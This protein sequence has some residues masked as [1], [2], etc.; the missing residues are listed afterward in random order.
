MIDVWK[1]TKHDTMKSPPDGVC[2]LSPTKACSLRQSG[3]SATKAKGPKNS[4]ILCITENLKNRGKMFVRL[5]RTIKM[6]V[7]L[8]L[9]RNYIA[10]LLSTQVK[11]GGIFTTPYASKTF[12]IPQIFHNISK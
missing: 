6:K 5:L 3:A 4:I 11:V 2:V 1:I 8:G 9:K 12:M 10:R 7:N